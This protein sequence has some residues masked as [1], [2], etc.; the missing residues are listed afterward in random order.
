[1]IPE[2][3]HFAL[4]L[5]LVLALVQAIV[6]MIGASRNR[7]AL[8]AV[9]RPAAQGQF[10]FI[11]FS[12]TCL[13]WAF[14]QSDFS[15][16]LAAANSHSATP[17]MYKITG[18]WGNHE[19]SLLL[20]AMSLSLWTVAVTVFSRNLPDAFVARVLGVLGWVSTGFLSFLL[21]TS[22]PFERLL[23]AVGEGRDLNPLLQDPGMIIHP[24]LLYM[25]YVGFSVAFAFAIAALLSGRLDAAWARWSRPWTTVA[26]VFL[27][28][29]I[30][31][32]SGWAYYELG[33]GGWWFW[34]PV[35]NASFMPWL[36]GT[37]LM[38][39]LA[40]TE[41]RGA[42]RSWTVLLAISAFS[43]SL[44]GTF[45]VRSGVITSVHA[46]A[47]DPKRG[48]FILA[49]LVIVIGVSLLLYAW[50]APRL[51][52]GGSFS[53]VSRETS[54]LGNNV[55]LSVAS[56]SVLLG[57]M[58]PLFLD[59]LGM[60]KISVGP[61][62]F[63]SVFIPLMTPVVVLMMF[64]P[65][66]RW[67]DDDLAK[68][69][70]KVAPAFIASVL[71][72]LGTAYAVDHVTWRTVLGLSLAAW[73][74]LAS[75]QLL[76]GRITERAG[77]AMGARLRSI[78]AA[79]WGMW[80]AHLGVGVFIIGVTLVGSLESHVDVRMQNGQHAE[81]AGYTFT[82][83]GVRDA[84]GPNYDAAR[85]TIDVTR[86]ERAIATLTPEKRLYLA[87]GMPM[88]EASIDIGPFRDVYVSLG[89][90]LED[91][92]WIVS[93]YYK[94]FISWIWLGCIMM[95]LGGVFAAADRRYRRLAAREATV[96]ANQ[97]VA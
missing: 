77:A 66:L 8:M 37:A 76:A 2:L 53:L 55:L 39:S 32:G 96:A 16:Q 89:E 28:A 4:V 56:A 93:V 67:K 73:V 57:T 87:Q 35:E 50:R 75:I 5:A 68:A 47:T 45:I 94:P 79:W 84:D 18:V 88:T 72:G 63:E 54:L 9:G 34:D 60:G 19:G 41:K 92:S 44:L 40:V 10:F 71:I 13:T 82:F 24:P 26:W 91:G 65:F 80:L 22:N 6:P 62:Y 14:I 27:T 23:P 85:A 97:R 52:G 58:Y 59:A 61:P 49:L 78:T 64:G 46:F 31:I 12:Y 51:G 43:L 11:L 29:G 86:G 38:H 69:V 1:M 90:Q 7:L 70:R 36:L 30:A 3:G 95:G 17:L 21:V 20:W 33:W 74:V 42:F 83:R 81:L 25:G 48:L 15:V